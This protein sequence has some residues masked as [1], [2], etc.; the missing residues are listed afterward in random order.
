MSAL[1]LFIFFVYR[2]FGDD[3][4]GDNSFI[5][6]VIIFFFQDQVLKKYAVIF[7]SGKKTNPEVLQLPVQYKTKFNA[8]FLILR[9]N[10]VR[11]KKINVV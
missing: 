4:D 1:L 6:H 5:G 7:F 10:E 8:I 11:L 3:D 2:E 9:L